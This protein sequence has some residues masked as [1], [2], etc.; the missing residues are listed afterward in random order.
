MHEAAT[1]RDNPARFA[2]DVAAL[3]RTH[4]D[5]LA[6]LRREARGALAL[7]AYS[8]V[9]VYDGV[10]HP[11]SCSPPIE[12]GA[13]R[14]VEAMVHGHNQRIYSKRRDEA[15]PKRP[16]DTREQEPRRNELSIAIG[17]VNQ[18]QT[19]I[20]VGRGG[21]QRLTPSPLANPF[22]IGFDGAR[23]EVI[24]RYRGWLNR[25]V[26]AKNPA[27]LT[28]LARIA[29]LARREP[30]TLVCHCAPQRCHAEVVR[31]AVRWYDRT[32]GRA[33]GQAQNDPRGLDDRLS[34]RNLDFLFE[35]YGRRTENGSAEI[36]DLGT[37]YRW[38]P[39]TG[40]L[41]V[42]NRDGEHDR[43]ARE[44]DVEDT[45]LAAI[46]RGHQARY[47]DYLAKRE[48]RACAQRFC[49]G[50]D[51]STTGGAGARLTFALGE[52][53]ERID[54]EQAQ[55]RPI[56]AGIAVWA[57]GVA[58]SIYEA[59]AAENALH[60]AADE[61]RRIEGVAGDGLLNTEALAKIGL[62]G[63]HEDLDRYL[64]GLE[65][66]QERLREQR[67]G[68]LAEQHVHEA[69]EQSEIT[70]RPE[71]VETLQRLVREGRL[72]AETIVCDIRALSSLF[73]SRDSSF[74][75]RLQTF[76]ALVERAE[77]DRSRE[78]DEVL[79]HRLA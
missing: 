72:N 41:S 69:L 40:F 45:H 46:M 16:G 21:Y 71:V 7:G 39:R 30:V 5:A 70:L 54:H 15:G 23:D 3:L 12:P 26:R 50:I 9:Q 19:G 44:G 78:H 68:E 59:M 61:L 58:D 42:S 28:E 60:L 75:Q 17:N 38:S 56:S 33:N 76:E 47:A 2:N 31:D 49:D 22:R 67:G 51:G 73:E 25:E 27:I 53:L 18:G 43:D 29:D 11:V 4:P 64:E 34:R 79:T 35:M 6:S 20:Y 1:S 55:G 24:E 77:H 48:S 65:R 57:R 62:Y 74:E 37:S 14:D 13:W 32:R 10:V 66:I 52:I 36:V 63:S 8:L